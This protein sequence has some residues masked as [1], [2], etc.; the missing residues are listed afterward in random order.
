MAVN[1]IVDP[2]LT[3]RRFFLFVAVAFPL[4]VLLGFARTYYLKPFFDAPPVPSLLVHLH[5]ALMTLWIVLFAAQVWL[6]SSKRIRIHQKLGLASIVLAVAITIFGMTTAVAAAKYGSN[7]T[8]PGFPP[9][10]FMIVPFA[11]MIVFAFLFAGALYYRKKAATHKRLILL[12]ILNFLPPAIGRWPI[13]AVAAL[14]PI[15]FFGIP[16]LLAIIFVVVDTWRHKK[17]NKPFAIAAALLI[18]SHPIRIMLSGTDAWLRFA[19]WLTSL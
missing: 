4:A 8:P 7:S 13:G 14:G 2:H 11:D 15:A 16:D 6:I 18:A 9:L 5:G 12:T 17:L 19:G 10:S 3:T 1:R